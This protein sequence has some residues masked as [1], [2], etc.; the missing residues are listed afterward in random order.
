MFADDPA[1]LVHVVDAYEVEHVKHHASR[2]VVVE[3]AAH[4]RARDNM[5]DDANDVDAHVQPN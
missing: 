2:P 5:K 1:L 4:Q 3:D